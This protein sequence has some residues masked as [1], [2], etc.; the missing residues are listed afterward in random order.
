MRKA[1]G[2]HVAEDAFFAEIIAFGSDKEIKEDHRMGE[3]VITT[4]IN[5]AMPLIRYRTGQAVS[6]TIEEC[7]CG[8]TF[9]RIAT[10]FSYL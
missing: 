7:E 3:L 5:E 6:K 10:P 8:R 9:M 2:Q 1:F 4:L